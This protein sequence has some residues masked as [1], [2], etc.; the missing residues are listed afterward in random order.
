M[1]SP[2]DSHASLL[3]LP[4]E[5]REKTITAISGHRCY[6]RFGRLSP[7]GSLVKTLLESE[8]WWSPAKRLKWDAQAISSKRITYTERKAGSHSKKSAKNLKQQD[9]PACSVGAPHKRE[10]IWIVA[11]RADTGAE[12]LQYERKNRVHASRS[13]SYSNRQRKWKNKQKSFS[14][15][16]RTSN[17]GSC[18]NTRTLADSLRHRS[19]KVHKDLQP[20]FSDGKK[21]YGIGNQWNDTFSI[22]QKEDFWKDFPTQSPVCRR[23]DGIPF[24]VDRLTISFPKWRAES[25][26]AYGNAW[27]PQV[28]YK[29]FRAIEAEEKK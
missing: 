2:E 28:A 14:R 20:K 13:P 10:R 7:L 8:P 23:N 26:K 19:N 24:D 27:V 15:C 25:I 18:R 17:L 4:A 12:T 6:E 3:A 22:F 11:H 16:C 21:S 1:F 29:I 9:I 5:E